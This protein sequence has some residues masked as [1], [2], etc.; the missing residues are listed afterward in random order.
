MRLLSLAVTAALLAAPALAASGDRCLM[1]R[2]ID[3]FKDAKRDAVTLTEGN[4]DYRV[5]FIGACI[6]L[7]QAI[8]IATVTATSCFEAGDKVVFRDATGFEQSCIASTVT[9]L[10]KDEKPDA[11]KTP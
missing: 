1:G 9:Y 3:G 5:E 6:G 8:S 4:H 11:E 7:D 2:Q 10:L